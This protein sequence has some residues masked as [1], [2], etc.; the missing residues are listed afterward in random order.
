MSSKNTMTEETSHPPQITSKEE[1]LH[2][3]ST[4]EFLPTLVLR[5]SILRS[6]TLLGE[7]MVVN[8]Y[9]PARQHSVN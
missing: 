6:L 3:L 5:H 2:D 7:I 4:L 1:L 8:S 9:R